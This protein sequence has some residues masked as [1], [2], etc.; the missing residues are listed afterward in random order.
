MNFQ[1]L[2]ARRDGEIFKR[3]H[4]KIPRPHIKR[5]LISLGYNQS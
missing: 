5:P 3:P 4:E 2:A 1:P